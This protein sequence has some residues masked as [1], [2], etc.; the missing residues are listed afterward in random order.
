MP[1]D[2]PSGAPIAAAAS[3]PSTNSKT[4]K[5]TLST[6]LGHLAVWSLFQQQQQNRNVAVEKDANLAASLRTL[7]CGGR[8]CNA[9]ATS[10]SAMAPRP[11]RVAVAWR[12]TR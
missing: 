11:A 6:T 3:N 8:S 2:V 1:V 4:T 9:A 10:R 7:S 5:P 12:G